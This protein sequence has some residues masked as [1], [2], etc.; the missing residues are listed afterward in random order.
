MRA[1]GLGK[2]PTH[3]RSVNF[4]S[5]PHASINARSVLPESGRSWRIFS[6]FSPAAA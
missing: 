2:A 4:N 3:T 1:A 6:S 5:A